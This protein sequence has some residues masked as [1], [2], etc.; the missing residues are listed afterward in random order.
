MDIN[1]TLVCDKGEMILSS[2]LLDN[3]KSYKLCFSLNNINSSKI[4]LPNL[5]SHNIYELLDKINPDL[6][7]KIK[8]M[9]IY[10][11]DSADILIVLKHIAKE[12]G[13]KQKYIL[14][15][16]HRTIDFKNNKVFFVNKD[17]GLMDEQLAIHY[18]GIANITTNKCEALVYNFGN[19]EIT[20]A[21][22]NISDLMGGGNTNKLIDANFE[23]HFQMT[24]KDQLPIY[25]ENLIGLMIKKLFYNLK[26]FIDKLI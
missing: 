26:T 18:M 20:I 3:K 22:N 16:A 6:I 12:V 13:I 9:K 23:T 24:M 4:N 21:N 5:L 11:Q 1:N 15:N 8:I 10:N 2:Y 7:E 25:M 19:L 14:F 17:I